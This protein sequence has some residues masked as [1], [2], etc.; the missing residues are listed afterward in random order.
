MR[1]G[2]AYTPCRVIGVAINS[3]M[4]G[5]H[6][7][8]TDE[9]LVEFYAAAPAMSYNYRFVRR[10]VI[11]PAPTDAWL[12]G[13]PGLQLYTRHGR[14]GV[15]PASAM[16]MA[17]N[18]RFDDRG[19]VTHLCPAFLRFLCITFMIAHGAV[20]RRYDKLPEAVYSGDLR[21]WQTIVPYP[22]LVRGAVRNTLLE[23]KSKLH[24][25]CGTD[26]LHPHGV[27]V[28]GKPVCTGCYRG[29][30]EPAGWVHVAMLASLL[31]APVIK[32]MIRPLRK[33]GL[34]YALLGTIARAPGTL[35]EL[36]HAGR[37]YALCP[38]QFLADNFT[39]LDTLR[40]LVLVTSPVVWQ[41]Y[42]GVRVAKY[43]ADPTLAASLAYFG[44]CVRPPRRGQAIYGTPLAEPFTSEPSVSLYQ[45]LVIRR[46]NK[47]HV[48]MTN[49]MYA[50]WRI[51]LKAAP[52]KVRLVAVAHDF[53]MPDPTLDARELWAV[54]PLPASVTVAHA[55]DISWTQLRM[56]MGVTSIYLYGHLETAMNGVK[57]GGV[58]AGLASIRREWA[59][60]T[61][62]TG[63][64]T[65]P[66]GEGKE[67]AL[68]TAQYLASGTA[69]PH[70]R[71]PV[72]E[73]QESWLAVLESLHIQLPDTLR[74]RKHG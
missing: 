64:E 56:L 31:G 32:A 52:G 74:D 5:R 53:D 38:E 59:V 14:T 47:K 12:E 10:D 28:F 7:L 17:A 8:R 48:V 26:T 49:D 21:T 41:L 66:L 43:A 33:P 71:N 35:D 19:C 20:R 42:L 60:T 16:C 61:A 69:W 6:V 37:M 45:T 3:G 72:W 13:L 34:R 73:D 27:V 22:A 57:S 55:E 36:M 4:V 58:F 1:D 30:F 44:W 2:R 65:T 54:R 11:A 9:G 50:V 18:L 15:E 23:C 68:L 25:L 24:G 46:K 40:Q 63:V 62:P 29:T 67:A 70:T 39:D 51:L